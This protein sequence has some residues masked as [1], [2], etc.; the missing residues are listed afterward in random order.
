MKPHRLELSSVDGTQLNLEALY[1]IAPSCFTEVKDDKTGELRHVV[2]FKTLRQLL[3]DNAVE[4]ADEMYQFTWPGKQEAR[5]EAARPTTK[6]LR[7]VVE[8]SV[9]WDNTQ[10]LYIEGDNLEV[11]KLLQKSYMGKVKMI[12][13]DPPY[14]TGNDFVYDDDF[15]ASQDDYDLFAGNVDE[16]GNRYR[17]NTETNGRFHSDWCSMMYSRLMVA[18]SLLTED[19]VIFVSIDDNEQ[20]NL[21]NICDEIFGDKNFLG[22]ITIIVKPEGRR[23]GSFAKC[24]ESCLVYAKDKDLVECNEIEVEGATYQYFDEIGGF[25]LKGLR[26]RNVK[27][28]N[29]TNRPNLRYPFYVDINHP[30]QNNLFPVTTIANN[31]YV[32]V[33][34]SIID[35]LE[36]VWRWGKETSEQKKSQ[37]TAY[38]GPDGIIRI[39]Q[40]ERKL[41]QT[42]KTVWIDKRFISN[43]GTK[44]SIDLLGKGIFDYPKPLKLVEQ[45]LQIGSEEESIIL[46]F[47]SGSSTTAHAV[48]QLN[49]EDC[50]NRKYIMVQLPEETPEDS[51]ARKAGYNTIPEIAKERIRRAGK[52]IKEES[53]LT[54]QNLDTGFRVFRLADSNFEEV[55]KAPGEYDQSQLDLF[56]NN[57]KS[58]RTDLDLLF[59]AMLSWGVQLSLPMTSEEVDGKM[60]YSVN[61]GDLVAC[62]AEDI[63]ETIIKTMA[64]KQPLRVLFRDSCFTRDDAKI[65]VFETLKQLLDWS[66]EEAMKNIRV[67]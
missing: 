43:K 3:G 34:A 23:Y 2:N 4:D 24:H 52:K 14:N 29:S 47:F 67:I 45:I 31:N 28:F 64:E 51:E 13:I 12:Y 17:K 7:P 38:K 39:F 33:E 59:G 48:M 10:N 60:I 44:E 41:T 58:D 22:N 36:S 62:F 32:K 11:L 20:R 55:K 65:N 40:K 26:N 1:Q 19:G 27:A 50:G 30:D 56:L 61:D 42:A 66:E 25:N 8:D 5:R 21:K 53:P 15:A 35:G 18:R 54:T 57:V 37:L 49:A 46:D 9:D 16:L 6:T 63:T